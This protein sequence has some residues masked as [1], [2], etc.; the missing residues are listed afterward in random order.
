MRHGVG[1]T[2]KR[3][4]LKRRRQN[5]R[6]PIGISAGR[7]AAVGHDHKPRKVLARRTEAVNGPSPHTGLAAHRL[8]RVHLP[9]SLQVFRTVGVT[10]TNDG[11]VVG[12]ATEV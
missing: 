7:L 9:Y 10:R 2:T 8:A 5:A 1:P 12:N 4:A 6:S 11:Q 3:R